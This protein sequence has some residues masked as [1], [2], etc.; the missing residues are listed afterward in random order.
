MFNFVL[1]FNFREGLT[2][3]LAV[4]YEDGYF[5]PFITEPNELEKEEEE[6]PA[7]PMNIEFPI[8]IKKKNENMW[9]KG[10]DDDLK[11]PTKTRRRVLRFSEEKVEDVERDLGKI[12]QL[13]IK[14]V[15]MGS[16]SPDSKSKRSHGSG[17]NLSLQE[18]AIESSL[19]PKRRSTTSIMRRRMSLSPRRLDRKRF[20]SKNFYEQKSIF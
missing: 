8:Y 2:K 16:R 19:S 7:Y 9:E 12:F 13:D 14:P 18:I 3:F 4:F 10:E 5:N 11:S 20:S 1:C 15:K 17:L 6:E